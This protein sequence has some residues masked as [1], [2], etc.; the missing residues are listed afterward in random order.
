M[1]EAIEQTI[2]EQSSIMIQSCSSLFIQFGPDGSV[3]PS[4][5][6]FAFPV[7]QLVARTYHQQIAAFPKERTLYELYLEVCSYLTNFCRG[8]AMTNVFFA[9]APMVENGQLADT[10]FI[11]G[12]GLTA[13]EMCPG[14]SRKLG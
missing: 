4:L 6:L 2:V 10:P 1:I 5:Q 8:G 11:S 9:V 7:Q 13:P 3:N 12:F 14:E